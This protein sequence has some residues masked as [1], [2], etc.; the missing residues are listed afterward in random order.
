MT[1]EAVTDA[2]EQLR[3]FWWRVGIS[4]AALLLAF[5]LGLIP[6]GISRWRAVRQLSA[7]R[8]AVAGQLVEAQRE[9]RRQ[10][11]QNSLAAAALDARRGEFEAARQAASSFFTLLSQ[12]VDNPAEAALAPAARE[13]LR[14]LSAQRDEIITLLA[15]NDPAAAD[16]LAD[17]YMIYRRDAG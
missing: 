11:L 5:L 10:R 3:V 15:R 4:A 6:M 13:R 17:L 7:E 2:A 8:N 16:R 14:P 9:L 12:E 1:D